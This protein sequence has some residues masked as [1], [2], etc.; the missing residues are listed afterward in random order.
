VTATLRSSGLAVND[1]HVHYGERHA[2]RGVS[3]AVAPGQTLAIVGESGCGKSSTALAVSRLLPVGAT[4]EGSAV[5]GD[6]DLAAATGDTLRRARGRVVAYMPQD[7]MAALNPV[8]SA[9]R[10]IAEVLRLRRGDDRGR[11][12]AGAIDLLG[13]VGINEPAAVARRYAHEL[14]GGMRQRV[15]LAIALAARPEVLIA[16][17]PTTALDVTVQAGILA[18]VRELVVADQMALVW[19]THDIG[20]VAEIADTVAVMYGGL[21]V[22]QGPVETI[23]ES[24]SHP[25]TQALVQSPRDSRRAP[26]KAA[27]DAIP[28]SPPLGDFPSGCPFHPRCPGALEICPQTMAATVELGPGHVC[29]CHLTSDPA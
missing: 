21:I 17:E 12:A 10:Q 13:D 25:Y 20:V 11:A 27:F 23:F 6:L 14:S 15:M 22:E 28:G 19:I 1:L 26:P 5:I 16:D 8:Q 4:M 9:G 3:F 2:V 29:A 7:A 18:L 24:P